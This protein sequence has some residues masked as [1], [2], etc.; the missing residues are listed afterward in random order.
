M[1]APV[2]AVRESIRSALVANAGVLSLLRD[3][4]IHADPPRHAP[5]P[6]IAF[7]GARA[8]ENG[9]GS[10]EGHAIELDLGIWCRSKGSDEGLALADAVSAALPAPPLAMAGHRLINLIVLSVEPTALKDNETWRVLMR[11]RAVTEVV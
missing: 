11:L 5:F 4:K 10:D 1:S 8:R 7:V 2:T 9:T 6:H 3:A